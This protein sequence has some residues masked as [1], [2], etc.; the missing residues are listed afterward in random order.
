MPIGDPRDEFFYPTLTLMM[1]SYNLT[2]VILPMLSHKGFTLVVHGSQVTSYL[3][4]S[5]VNMH[6]SILAYSRTSQFISK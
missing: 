4:K 6:C 2:H 3:C 5:D 1:D